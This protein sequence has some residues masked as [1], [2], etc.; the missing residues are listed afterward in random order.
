MKWWERFFTDDEARAIEQAP[1]QSMLGRL[2]DLLPD[3][4][5][6]NA[7]E[8]RKPVRYLRPIEEPRQ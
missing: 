7:E 1:R 2:R 4:D 8:R 6:D 5:R 3:E